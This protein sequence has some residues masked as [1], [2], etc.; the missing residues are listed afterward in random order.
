M[1]LMVFLQHRGSF[2]WCWGSFSVVLGSS[3]GAGGLP[4][5]LG[6]FLL[7]G[8]FLLCWGSSCG[9]GGLSV[10]LGIFAVLLGMHALKASAHARFTQKVGFSVVELHVLQQEVSLTL[11]NHLGGNFVH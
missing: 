4:V 5:V 10:V 2:L 1:V 7:C 6:V 11:S 9:A 3:C 8:I